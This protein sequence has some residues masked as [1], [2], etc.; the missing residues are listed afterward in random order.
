MKANSEYRLLK[1]NSAQP[2]A[3]KESGAYST[4]EKS[5]PRTLH[6]LFIVG[7][8]MTVATMTVAK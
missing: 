5:S 6:V 4:S 8:T 1:L 2:S 7:L 3:R